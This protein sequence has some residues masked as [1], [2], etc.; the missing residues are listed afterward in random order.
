[1]NTPTLAA[2][3]ID[4]TL[5]KNVGNDGNPAINI[6]AH[7]LLSLLIVI[8]TPIALAALLY[9]GYIL[10]TSAG[11]PEAYKKA[12]QNLGFVVVGIFLIV[13]ATTIVRFVVSLLNIRL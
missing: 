5:F 7:N 4:F 2:G 3:L 12:K 13:F 6:L 11:K 10:I 9:T 1:M 8:A